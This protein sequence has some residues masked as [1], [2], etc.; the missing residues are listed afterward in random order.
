ML[1]II[2]YL[3]PIHGMV[4]KTPLPAGCQLE[5]KDVRCDSRKRP[6]MAGDLVVE[7]QKDGKVVCS[8][9]N[10]AMYAAKPKPCLWEHNN[11]WAQSQWVLAPPN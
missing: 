1:A 3:Q 10:N 11:T 9:R 5:G 2:Y 8:W 7:F 6:V 4:A